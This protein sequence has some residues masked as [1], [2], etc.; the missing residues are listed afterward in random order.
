MNLSFG[1][2]GGWLDGYFFID[3]TVQKEICLRDG[4]YKP[5]A[6]RFLKWFRKKKDDN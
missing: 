6:N 1:Q 3:N 2:D 4:T 5:K